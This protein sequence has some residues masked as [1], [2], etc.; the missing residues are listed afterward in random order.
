MINRFWLTC[1]G[2]STLFLARVELTPTRLTRMAFPC[3]ECGYVIRGH[4]EGFELDDLRV[5]WDDAVPASDHDDEEPGPEV[6]IITVG[7]S[8]PLRPQARALGEFG[9]APN[10]T[11][12]YL[13]ED[14]ATWGNAIHERLHAQSA[15]WRQYDQMLHYYLVGDWPRFDLAGRRLMPQSWQRPRNAQERHIA[16]LW[17]AQLLLLPVLPDDYDNRLMHDYASGAEQWD[18][19]RRLH[20]WAKSGEAA[21]T[22]S[23]VQRRLFEALQLYI[24]NWES[25]VPGFIVRAT[26]PSRRR[27][28]AKLRVARDDFPILRDL[29]VQVYETC[30]AALPFA[31]AIL[32]SQQRGDPDTFGPVPQDLLKHNAKAQPPRSVTAFASSRNATKPPWFAE[33]P[34]WSSLLPTL[35]NK[36]LRNSLGHASARHDIATGRVVAD[37][38]DLSFLELTGAVFDLAYPLLMLL[39]VTKTMR[40]LAADADVPTKTPRQPGTQT[41]D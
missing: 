3:P 16:A 28:L 25:W 27:A 21:G 26:D 13:L 33:W 9:S 24:R 38:V 20:D 37:K 40:L 10:L 41:P 22:F 18:A 12:M 6:P 34:A 31:I 5:A 30:Y 8:V 29:Y 36:D 14:R 1:A 17:P 2:C 23:P 32:N 35:L 39:Q 11:F 7:T 4:Y 15:L 19:N